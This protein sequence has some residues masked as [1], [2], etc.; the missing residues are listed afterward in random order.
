MENFKKN[1]K[2]LAEDNLKNPI[3]KEGRKGYVSNLEKQGVAY[4][5]VKGNGN[6]QITNAYLLNRDVLLALSYT[7]EKGETV[8]K[9][10]ENGKEVRIQ[11]NRKG[12][13]RF[14]DTLLKGYETDEEK[15]EVCK[16]AINLAINPKV[17]EKETD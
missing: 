5:N 15:I 1:L 2:K 16:E 11:I 13:E 14:C 3:Q 4:M 10:T 6:L 8:P 7:L 9:R 17:F 12:W